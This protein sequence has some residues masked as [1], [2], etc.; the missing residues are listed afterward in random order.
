MARALGRLSLGLVLAV[1]LPSPAPAQTVLPPAVRAE[2]VLLMDLLDGKVLYA[3]NAEETHGPASLVKLMTL[4][5]AYEDLEAGKV[6]LDDPVLI[7][8]NAAQT[9]RYRMGL[10]AGQRAPLRVL[11]EGVAIASANDAAMA[12]AEHLEGSESAFVDRMNEAAEELGLSR[13]H[14]ANPHGLPDP[15]QWSTAR[16]LARLTGRLLTDFP[17]EREILGQRSFIYLGRL[18]RR[19]TSLFRDPGGVAALKTG[20]TLESGF[21]LAVASARSG[22]RLLCI[23]LGAE[24]R[25]LSFLEAARLLKFGFG[26]EPPAR[27]IRARRGRLRSRVGI[28]GPN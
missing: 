9:P 28:G 14:F 27:K 12:L 17:E 20:F 4:Y 5:L 26:E 8:F 2:A 16:D 21:N 3:K 22:Q 13:T 25:T 19:R 15:R 7:S 23:V 24:T 6:H 18:Y 11:L 10:R 1:F